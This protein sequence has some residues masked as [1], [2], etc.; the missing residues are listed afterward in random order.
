MSSS[1]QGTLFDGETLAATPVTLTA[2]AGRLQAD[3]PVAAI[4]APLSAVRC[5]DRLGEVPRFLYLPDGRTI[6]TADNAAVDQLL[7]TQRR[8][9]VIRFVHALEQHSRSAAVATVLLI[10]TVAGGIWWGLPQLARR[11]ALAVPASIEQQAGRAGLASLNQI[12]PPS[13]L[14][15]SERQRVQAQLDRLMRAGGITAS[16]Q[17]EFR[18]MGG[19]FPNAFAL[20]GGIIVMSDELVKLVDDDDEIAA[21]L[22]HEIGHWQKRHGLQTVL[23]SSAALLVVS[24]I[25]GDLSTL[26]TFAS[27]IP[28][29]LLQRGYSREF[30]TEADDYA[31]ELLLR[32]Q[33]DPRRLVSILTKLGDA[34][35][36]V[37]NDLT[38]LSTHPGTTQ[39]IDRLYAFAQRLGWKNPG[40]LAP[41]SRP[42][43][44]EVPVERQPDAQPKPVTRTAP[45]YPAHLRAQKLSGSVTLE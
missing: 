19:T 36:K 24:T 12:L 10:A 15:T 31:I 21:V 41:P 11:A 44:R 32:A 37:G 29:V 38:Y 6:E 35:P 14:T 5:S 25:T 30:E 2:A 42:A 34:R 16:P 27:T 8:G 20:P 4:D 18:S 17:L 28:F 40:P 39:R 22:A 45:L 23:R 26:T 3:A 43:P 7:A 1:F 13:G 9:S 33:A